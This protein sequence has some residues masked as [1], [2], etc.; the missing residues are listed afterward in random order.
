MSTAVS[1]L[2]RAIRI[3]IDSAPSTIAKTSTWT[4]VSEPVASGR[5]EVRAIRRSMRWS[6]RWLIA[7]A[8]AAA[9]QMPTKPATDWRSGGQPGT[10]RNMP[11]IAVNTISA[12]TRG[13]VSSRYCWAIEDMRSRRLAE[14]EWAPR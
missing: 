1:G 2:T 7:A 5:C 13:L 3:V 10:A 8:E 12:T 14:S 9:S 4:G 11:M 6:I